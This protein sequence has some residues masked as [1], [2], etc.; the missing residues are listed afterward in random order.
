MQI[1]KANLNQFDLDSDP[2]ALQRIGNELK[3][4]I[5]GMVS[6][7]LKEHEISVYIAILI[8]IIEFL[9]VAGFAFHNQ[10]IHYISLIS[11]FLAL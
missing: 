5:F 7:L 8:P 11:I 4:T 10:V 1:E 6:L 9:Q 3:S 2:N